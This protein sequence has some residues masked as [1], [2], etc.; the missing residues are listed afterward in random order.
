M[1]KCWAPRNRGCRARRPMRR[2]AATRSDSLNGQF[3]RSTL[4]LA[5]P[6]VAV[7]TGRTQLVAIDDARLVLP[8]RK[9][10]FRMHL[11]QIE[12]EPERAARCKSYH[13]GHAAALDPEG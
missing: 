9:R 12:H 1:A 2:S 5:G 3:E 13:R 4:D 11:R 6:H 10:R 8:L 7:R